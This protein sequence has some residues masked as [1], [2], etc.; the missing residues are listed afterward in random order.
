MKLNSKTEY[1][2]DCQ[3]LLNCDQITEQL[4]DNPG[5]VK[6]PVNPYAVGINFTDDHIV[7]NQKMY[8]DWVSWGYI[9]TDSIEWINYYPIKDFDESSVNTLC[10]EL[11][12]VPKHVWI[13]SI[14]PGKCIPWHR[15]LENLEKEW[16][17]EGELVRYTVFLN[18]PEIGQ[19]FV[20]DDQCFHMIPKG[21][22]YKWSQW[23]YYHLGSNT[24]RS[25]KY[26]LHIIGIKI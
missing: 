16:Q 7:E 4:V 14:R 13:S 23:N 21:S 18:D 22:I 6:T 2:G 19:F 25:K 8:N 12:I 11:L 17:K 9:E 26:L 24:G 20:V 5:H 15:D 10:R 3:R 1:V